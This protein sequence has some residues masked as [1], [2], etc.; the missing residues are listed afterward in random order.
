MKRL[1]SS[2]TICSPPIDQEKLGRRI[3]LFRMRRFENRLLPFRYLIW[4]GIGLSV[5]CGIAALGAGSLPR[6]AVSALLSRHFAADPLA[7]GDVWRRLILTLLP[8]CLAL[9][10]ASFT[11]FGGVASTVI[12]A[13]EGVLQG[14]C[15]YTLCRYGCPGSW[16]AVYAAWAIGRLCLLLTVAVTAGR[17]VRCRAIEGN[18]AADRKQALSSILRYTLILALE[19][20]AGTVLCAAVGGLYV[21]L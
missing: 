6:S 19:L 14:V 20:V 15:L 17:A 16:I 18:G 5:G 11:Y 4:I 21:M 1:E 7:F 12:M 2:A 9:I 8:V 10:G 13:A 3:A